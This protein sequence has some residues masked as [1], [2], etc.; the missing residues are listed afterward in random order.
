MIMSKQERETWQG[1]F[2]AKAY[3]DK[4]ISL[5]LV[6][7]RECFLEY[8]LVDWRCLIWGSFHALSAEF[9][10]RADGSLLAEAE[11]MHTETLRQKSQSKIST[12]LYTYIRCSYLFRYWNGHEIS[13]K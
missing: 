8:N 9:L 11:G 6:L 2:K 10:T 12:R 13:Q 4:S 5:T 3:C 7:T 1:N